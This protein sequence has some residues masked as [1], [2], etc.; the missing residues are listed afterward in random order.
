MEL[1]VGE[2]W[3]DIKGYEG[4]YQAS[5]I[6]NV[7]SIG[8]YVNAKNNSKKYMKSIILKGVANDRGY[9]MVVLSK[10]G[11]KRKVFV[12]RLIAETFIENP[13]NYTQVNHKDEDKT[14]N[15]IN[16]LEWCS[17]KYNCNYGTRNKRLAGRRKKVC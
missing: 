1:E 12:H 14:N 7:K 4:L 10:E 17:C 5:S 16:N 6:G 3:K 9:Y 15:N 2:I 13:K 8:R 11:K